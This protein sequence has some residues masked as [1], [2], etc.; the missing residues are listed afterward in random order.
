MRTLEEEDE[1]EKE[2]GKKSSL[3]SSTVKEQVDTGR[4]P[5]ASG[6]SPRDKQ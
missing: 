3:P 1:E 6:T 4:A 2:G 5:G